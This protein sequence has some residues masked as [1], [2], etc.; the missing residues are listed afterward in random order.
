MFPKNCEQYC[1]GHYN[2]TPD[3]GKCGIVVERVGLSK[4]HDTRR[5]GTRS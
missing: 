3:L 5:E 4:A 2:R 1:N